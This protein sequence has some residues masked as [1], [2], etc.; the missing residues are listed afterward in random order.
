[1]T[2]SPA[3]PYPIR[4]VTEGEFDAFHLVDEHAFHGSPASAAELERALSLFEWPR[5]LAAFD[6]ATP[7]G[8]TGIYSFQLCVPGAL[9]PAAGVSWVG[10]LPTHRRQGVLRSLMRRQLADIAAGDEPLAVL[11][12]SEA[13][14]Y[15]RYGYGRASWQLAFTLRR[16]EGALG[17]ASASGLA[18][19]GLRM[20]LVAPSDALAELAKIYDVVLQSRPGFFARN[21]QWWQRVLF[22]PEDQRKGAS[23]LRCVLAEDDNGPRGYALY[24]GTGR[25]ED[26]FFLPDGSLDVRELVAADPAASA[27]LW[28]NLLSRDLTNEFTA[29]LRPVDD[30]LLSQLADP[31]RT[32][33]QLSDGLWVRLIDLPRALAARRYSCPVSVVLDV[34]DNDL[35]GNAGRWRLSTSAG[36]ADLTG[37]ADL[38]ADGPAA[39]GLAADGLAADGLAADGLAADGLAARCERT[40]DPA[41]LVL[42]V[43]SLGAAYLGGVRLGT[44]ADAGLV[45]EVRPGTVRRLSAAMSWDP[46]PWC[47]KIF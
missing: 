11:W 20:R 23:P 21:E 35:P 30:P 9:L 17:P 38:A 32:R 1:M 12:A 47:P 45:T 7:V 46:A 36:D 25:W 16:G 13:G 26:E 28:A 19:D 18:S 22:D 27:Q 2:S 8:I 44:L 41:D 33:P 42:D 15:G 5:S 10:V 40:T 24:T 37:D 43:A 31:R 6:G 34:R 3:S 39:D 14:I 29:R 4:P